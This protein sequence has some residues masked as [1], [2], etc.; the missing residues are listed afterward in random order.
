NSAIVGGPRCLS[1]PPITTTRGAVIAPR[2][3]SSACTTFGA[4]MPETSGTSGCPPVATMTAAGSNSTSSSAVTSFPGMNSKPTSRSGIHGARDRH[5]MGADGV[6]LRHAEA[7][8]DLVA[9]P[10]ANLVR[11]LGVGDECAH[12]PDQVGPALGEDALRQRGVRNAAGDHDRHIDRG[13]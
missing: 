10:R 6:A 3:T 1:K 9:A 4:P 5:A 2:S 11:K 12:H 8:A 7:H 13:F